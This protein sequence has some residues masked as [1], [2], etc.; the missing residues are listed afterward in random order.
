MFVKEMNELTER[1]LEVYHKG[2]KRNVL[3]KLRLC[4]YICDC[5]DKG[6]RLGA[7]TGGTHCQRFGCASDS[8]STIHKLVCCDCCFQKLLLN[9]SVGSAATTSCAAG[10]F[11]FDPELVEYDV[12]DKYPVGLSDGNSGRKLKMKRVSFSSMRIAVQTA[13]AHV[14]V[15]EWTPRD[16]REELAYHRQ[17][18]APRLSGGVSAAPRPLRW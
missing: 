16:G 8:I 18:A 6:K 12:P 4:A 15:G 17:P 3:V 9:Q 13:F 10:C 2:L 5:P 11:A 14:S 7:L 1:G